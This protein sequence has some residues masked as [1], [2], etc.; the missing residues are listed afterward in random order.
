M[1]DVVVNG[2][3]S[4]GTSDFQVDGMIPQKRLVQIESSESLI[5]YPAAVVADL[6]KRVPMVVRIFARD[7]VVWWDRNMKTWLE[8][9]VEDKKK[10]VKAAQ[11][12]A[13]CLEVTLLLRLE[14]ASGLKVTTSMRT[15]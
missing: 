1:E 5:W 14:E 2:E 13:A 4:D 10:P 12:K 9:I 7:L 8:G 6:N 3:I 15:R 11:L